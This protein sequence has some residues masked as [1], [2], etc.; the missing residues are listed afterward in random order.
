VIFRTLLPEPGT[1]EIGDLLARVPPLGERASTERPYTLANFIASADGRAAFGGRSGPLGDDGDKAMFHGL[2]EHVDAVLVGTRT[3]RVERYGRLIPDPARRERRVAR[4][5]PAEPIACVITRSGDV[6]TDI[7][8]MRDPDAIVIVFSPVDVDLSG[9]GARVE[10]I[11]LEPGELTLA[12]ALGRLRSDHNVRLL[13]CEGGPTLFGSA[14][15]ERV[16][17]ELFLTVAPKLTGGG[18]GPPITSGPEL[19]EPASLTLEWTLERQGSLFL[20]YA[21]GRP[22][23]T[24]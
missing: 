22:E 7:P 10:L 18:T 20:R 8:L 6:P 1:I 9:C 3:L 12:T 5:L 21:I 17:D 11:R 2:R 16:V 13:L 14:V 24:A 15:H 23:R 4:G 19:A